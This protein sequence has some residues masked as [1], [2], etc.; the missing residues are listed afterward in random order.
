[1]TATSPGRRRLTRCLV[2]SPRRAVPAI[3][4]RDGCRCGARAERAD[5]GDWWWP[6]AQIRPPR[7]GSGKGRCAVQAAASSSRACLVA[8]SSE[9]S[10]PSMRRISSTTPSPSRRSTVARAWPPATSFSM[11][12]VGAGE[13]GDLRQMG[14]AEDLAAGAERPQPLA[15]DP[16]RLAADPGVDLVEDDR[17]GAGRFAESR[18]A[19]ASPARAR[20]RRPP[21][22]AAPPRC[23]GS[24]R[25]A[26]RPSRGRWGRTRRDGARGRPPASRP[27]SRAAPARP[28]P[29]ARAARRRRSGPR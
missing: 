13:R 28:R 2:R 3:G 17:P 11:P 21:R 16:R 9:R 7:P 22:A 20:R 15:H 27:P 10:P 26:A 19:P 24:A 12:E 8:A 1:M 18:S 6:P 23:P 14:D 25:P 29:A 5:D 4:H